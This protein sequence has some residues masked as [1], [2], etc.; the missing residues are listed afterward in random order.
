VLT[1][2]FRLVENQLT[3]HGLALHPPDVLIQPAVGG[4]MTLEF[5]RS[6]EAI[7]A[8]RAAVDEVLPQLA[9]YSASWIR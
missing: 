9:A 2:S 6:P 7:E 8:G 4:I 1:R 5:H 3:R